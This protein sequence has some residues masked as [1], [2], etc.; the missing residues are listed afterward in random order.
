MNNFDALVDKMDEI[1]QQTF[2]IN[3]L[4][5]DFPA[6]GIFN[7]E[8]DQFEGVGTMYRT[9]E[10]PVSELPFPVSY[11]EHDVT[12]VILTENGREFTVNNSETVNNQFV[13]VLR[14]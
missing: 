9:L 8:P 6:E 14:E 12:R 3:V 4:V 5:G 10:I 11:I 2:A 13:M 7:E 1:H